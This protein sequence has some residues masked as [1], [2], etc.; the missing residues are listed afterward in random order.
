MCNHFF[1]YNQPF[2]MTKIVFNL[3]SLT[4]DNSGVWLRLEDGGDYLAVANVL[5]IKP[6]TPDP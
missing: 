4:G 5:G 2:Q 6:T 3:T 1:K